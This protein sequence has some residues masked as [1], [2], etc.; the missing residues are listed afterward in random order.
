VTP[1][2]PK[3][4]AQPKAKDMVFAPQDYV[5]YPT[6]GVGQ[7]TGVETQE[8]AGHKLDVFVISFQAEKMI[9]RVPVAKV[10]TSGLRPISTR[11]QMQDA[12]ETLAAER[13]RLGLVQTDGGDLTRVYSQLAGFRIEIPRHIVGYRQELNRHLTRAIHLGGTDISLLKEVCSTA[14]QASQVAHH[15]IKWY[16]CE[17]K[18]EHEHSNQRQS[19]RRA[20]TLRSFATVVRHLPNRMVEM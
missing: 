17:A 15:V 19:A 8:I 13:A 6:H 3:P 11:K 7:I 2:K 5:V 1:A 4:A 12:L 9:L 20:T 16:E 10:S 14:I 18:P